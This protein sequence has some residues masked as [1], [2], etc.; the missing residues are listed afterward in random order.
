LLIPNRMVKVNHMGNLADKMIR[1]ARLDANFYIQV[2]DDPAAIRQAL[3]VV[4]IYSSFAGIG[5]GL[6]TLPDVEVGQFFLNLFVGLF[7]ALV[8]WFVWSFVTYFI[9]TTLFKGPQA[10]WRVVATYGE[11]LRAIGFAATPGILMIFILIPLIG[12]FLLLA[13]LV[14]MFIAAVIAVREALD[15][16][17]WRAICTCVVSGIIHVLFAILIVMVL[18]MASS[19]VS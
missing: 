14:W 15:F 7:S 9:G 3:F 11:L 4:L 8:L 6:L 13:A 18:G 17:T 19:V 12:V 1:A 10:P 16:S 5:A 2:M